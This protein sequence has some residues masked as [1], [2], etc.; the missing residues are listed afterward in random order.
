MS[1]KIA[2]NLLSV[3]PQSLTGSFVYVKNLLG[4]LVVLDRD[5]IYYLILNRANRSYFKNKFKNYPNVK[6]Y[7]TGVFYDLLINPLRVLSKLWAKV[8]KDYR[9]RELIIRG[10]IQHFFDK[11]KVD[12]I[13]FPSGTI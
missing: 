10:E 4:E 9:G 3:S 11:N 12:I 1:G 7:S 6:Y 8:K 2:I 13:F 5:N